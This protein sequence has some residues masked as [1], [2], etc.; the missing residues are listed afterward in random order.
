MTS[1]QRLLPQWMS[2]QNKDDDVNERK[3][4]V[5]QKNVLESG[6]PFLAFHGSI[7]YSY[8]ASDCSLLSEDIRV[9]LS[10]EAVIGFDI[11]W[12]PAYLKG[13]VKK[14]ALV[15]LCVSE[16]KCYLFHISSMT[17]FP[18]GL[19]LLLEDETIKKTGVGIGGDQWKLM[20]DFDI[21]LRG[22]VELA[23]IANQK[24]KC[25]ET[26]SLNGLVKHLFNK[27]LLKEKLVRCSNWAQFPLSD[28]QKIY[29]ATDAYAG[30]LIYQKLEKMSAAEQTLLSCESGMLLQPCELKEQLASVSRELLDL[31]AQVP[32]TP[33]PS[34]SALRTVD[35]LTGVLKK[36][37]SLRSMLLN[38]ADSKDK[39]KVE[40][41]SDPADDKSVNEYEHQHN[42]SDWV[43]SEGRGLAVS[44]SCASKER[45]KNENG[46][47]GTQVVKNAE[48]PGHNPCE[49]MER[50][51]LMSLDITEHE[52]RMLECHNKEDITSEE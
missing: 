44:A 5:T 7:L 36:L 10:E 1:Q 2:A 40:A 48:D 13:N 22:F 8:E 15:Q 46:G 42:K 45:E 6:L 25:K 29:A 24:L 49:G 31:A 9:S 32:D 47:E 41:I 14:V 30:L 19:K 27:Q 3:K 4:S 39:D 43:E 28:E 11:E 33:A 52:L 37:T 26:W 51:C 16:E 21:K 35:T 18:K 12:P 34:H 38:M 20:N 50:H 23:D 17:G